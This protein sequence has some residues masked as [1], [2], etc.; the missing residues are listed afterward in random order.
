MKAKLLKKIRKRFNWYINKEG[1]P[2]LIDHL[3]KEAE[4]INVEFC[5]QHYNYQQHDIEALI[6]VPLREWAWRTIKDIMLK[7]F[8]YKYIN[9]WYNLATKREKRG[10]NKS[11]YDKKQH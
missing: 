9:H 5:K 2:V 8:G 6:E 7:Q 3:K 11:N 1:F 4:I 10:K